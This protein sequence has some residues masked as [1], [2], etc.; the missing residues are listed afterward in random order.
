MS[1]TLTADEIKDDLENMADTLPDEDAG[2]CRA[3]L[4]LIRSL[5]AELAETKSKLANRKVIERAKGLIM[6]VC[7]LDEESAFRRLQK[8]SSQK[9]LKLHEMAEQIIAAAEALSK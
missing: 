5:E 9:N 1:T 7:G 3:A 2:I 8:M 4:D 6:K